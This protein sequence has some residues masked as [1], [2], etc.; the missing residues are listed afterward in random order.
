M[1]DHVISQPPRFSLPAFD[2]EL[3]VKV[4]ILDL[5]TTR[6]SGDVTD[7]R[8]MALPENEK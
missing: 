6:N 3:L 1:S 8:S 2:N 5:R 4:K 7:S